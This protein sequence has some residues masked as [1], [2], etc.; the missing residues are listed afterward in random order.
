MADVPDAGPAGAARKRSLPASG[1]NGRRM[2][3][4]S[5]HLRRTRS[6]R[7][8]VL[9]VEPRQ[10]LGGRVPVG[11]LADRGRQHVCCLGVEALGRHLGGSR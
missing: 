8:A 1:T 6:W 9:V 7:A 5:P 4:S 3:S 10:P 2:P 11:E